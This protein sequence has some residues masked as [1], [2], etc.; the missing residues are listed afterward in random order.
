MGEKS[1]VL[2]TGAAGYVGSHAVSQ[3]LGRG[4]PVR[5]ALRSRARAQELSET[6]ALQGLDPR[7]IEIVTADL[8]A[9]DGWPEAVSGAAD[10]LH[11]ASPFPAEAPANDDEIIIPAREGTLRVLR[12]ARDAG[13][14]RVVMTSS[15]A[16]VGY[17][18]KA[19]EH[20][21]EDD[22]TDPADDNTA[23]IRSKAIAERAAWDFIDTQG[24]DLEL[25]TLVPVGIFGPTL[26]T[27]LSTSVKFIQSM[28]T[29]ALDRVAPQYFGVV[30]V[31]DVATA[32]IQA[33]TASG[34]AGE[35]ILLAADGPAV[36]FLEIARMLRE[37]LGA[38]ASKVPTSEYSEAE[39]RELAQTVPALR[40]ALSRLGL[41]PQINNAKAKAVLDW[42]PRPISETIL[43]TAQSLIAKNLVS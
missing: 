12:H 21:T 30:D 27:H 42:E 14:R 13:C 26:G 18:A 17:S 31:R 8:T 15:F 4:Y 37:G 43:D 6:V 10:V 25:T 35:R 20:W 16:A 33:L 7:L 3:L 24:G 32:H 9:D 39:V 19:D 40:E 36:S 38:A 28:L 41:R 11:I 23:Y 5:V 2:V 34:A 29:G 22:W 1:L